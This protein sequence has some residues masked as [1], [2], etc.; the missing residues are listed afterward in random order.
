[1]TDSSDYRLFLNE[2]F[3]G[4]AK[5]MNAHFENIHDR[6]EAIEIQTTKTNGTVQH[7]EKVIL[8][9]LPHS[10]INCPQADKIDQIEKV[11]IGDDAVI[12]QKKMDKKEEHAKAIRLIMVAGIVV[13]IFISIFSFISNKHNIGQLKTEVDMINTPVKTRG[14]TIMWYPSGVVIDSLN[15]IK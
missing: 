13:T 3:E 9:N 10:V 12:R 6:L 8:E 5:L 2:R 4:M 14:G 1:M 15:K 11:L 7:H